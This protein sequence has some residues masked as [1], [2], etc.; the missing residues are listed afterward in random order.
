MLDWTL[1]KEKLNMFEIYICDQTETKMVS[2][3]VV[4]PRR[5]TLLKR[6]QK[7]EII[8]DSGRLCFGV[9]LTKKF[10]LYSSVWPRH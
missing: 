8:C 6:K 10:G 2:K 5:P 3:S 1:N 9:L 7:E 4:G